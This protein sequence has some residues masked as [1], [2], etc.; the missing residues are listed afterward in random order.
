MPTEKFNALDNQSFQ[1]QKRLE[2]LIAQEEEI[3]EELR[4]IAASQIMILFE[5][6]FNQD[7]KIKCVFYKST[8]N[9]GFPVA[10]YS[11]A[12]FM[13]IKDSGISF[14]VKNEQI[15]KILDLMNNFIDGINEHL[16]LNEQSN[17]I[18]E[19]NEEGRQFFLKSILGKDY[20]KWVNSQLENDLVEKSNMKKNKI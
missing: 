10:E 7:N 19:N 13:E 5:T 9:E 11:G 8:D 1:L 4:N 20:Y 15:Q 17:I 2:D 16:E 3:E 12:Y 6:Q 18:F 14:R